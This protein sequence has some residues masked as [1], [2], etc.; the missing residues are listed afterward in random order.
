MKASQMNEQELNALTKEEINI[1]LGS[2][3]S[4]DELSKKTK[5]SLIKQFK[6]SRKIKK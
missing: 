2:I 5:E 3:Y 1:A 6:K 4:E